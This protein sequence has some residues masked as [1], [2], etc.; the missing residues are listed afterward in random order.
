M[1]FTRAID[2]VFAKLHETLCENSGASSTERNYIDGQFHYFGNSSFAENRLDIGQL[3]ES[4]SD[5]F[6][7][8]FVDPMASDRRTI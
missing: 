3:L 1:Q 8:E 6:D 5:R 7:C 2:R 4:I